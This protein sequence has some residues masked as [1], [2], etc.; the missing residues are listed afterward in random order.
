VAKF[1]TDNLPLPPEADVQAVSNDV[2]PSWVYPLKLYAYRGNG[3]TSPLVVLDA[4]NGGIVPPPAYHFVIEVFN[5]A[6]GMRVGDSCIPNINGCGFIFD[7][8]NTSATTYQAILSRGGIDRAS[9]LM[10]DSRAASWFKCVDSAAPASPTPCV[11]FTDP[12]TGH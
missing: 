8:N 4:D 5:N 7:N 1:V 6:T 12:L 10:N 11:Q 2:L 3:T 9:A